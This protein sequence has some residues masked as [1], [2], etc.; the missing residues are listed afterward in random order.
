MQFKSAVGGTVTG[1]V[2]FKDTETGWYYSVFMFFIMLLRTFILFSL[3]LT[4]IK[5]R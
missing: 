5:T 4:F 3:L 1:S 2:T